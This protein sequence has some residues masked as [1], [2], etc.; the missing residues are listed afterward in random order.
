MDW[1]AV[2]AEPNG[3]PIAEISYRHLVIELSGFPRLPGWERSEAAKVLR[4]YCELIEIPSV[5]L[6]ALRACFATQM[7]RNNVP[8][9]T[10]MKIGGW[11]DLKTLMKYIRLAGIEVDNATQALSFAPAEVSTSQVVNLFQGARQLPKPE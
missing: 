9:V 4:T 8:A 7:L 2:G 10:V 5:R 1:E 3:S 6:H 11:K